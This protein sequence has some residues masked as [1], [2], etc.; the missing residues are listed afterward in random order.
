M[1]YQ[2]KRAQQLNCDLSTA[3]KFFSS[4]YNLAVI[5]PKDMGFTVLNKQL[6][7]DIYEGM[8][9][10]YRVSPIWN[11]PLRWQTKILAVEKEKRFVDFQQ[12]GPYA[13]WHHQHEFI[14]NEHGVLMIDT[15]DYELGFG[16][17]GDL[18]HRLFVKR[19]LEY[20][21]HYRVQVL[22]EMFNKKV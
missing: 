8:I 9:I 6:P 18:V 10:D 17:I 7:A 11:I 1:R 2:L 15:V 19:K 3:W 21:F 13:F 14:A 22:E 5:T 20:I 4:P 12:K 16:F